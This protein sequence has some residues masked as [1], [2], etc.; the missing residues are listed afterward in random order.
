MKHIEE[1]EL[2]FRSGENGNFPGY[3]YP[4][5]F[6]PMKMTDAI[7]LAPIMRREGRTIGTYLGGYSVPNQWNIK[8]TQKWVSSC[9]LSSEFPSFHYLFLCG[10]NNVIGIGSIM[11]FGDDPRVC[12]FVISV[13]GKHQG[14]GWGRAIAKTLQGIAFDVWGF[15]KIYWLNDITNRRSTKL[16]QS[17]G[18]ALEESYSDNYRLGTSGTGLWFRWSMA[19]PSDMFPGVLQGAD[20]NY[21]MT[22]KSAEMLKAVIHAKDATGDKE[23]L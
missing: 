6:R 16:A 13:F 23:N 9:V 12:Q 18:F 1:V 21:W 4:A 8:D 2:K 19:R 5:E 7:L 14:K 20:M 11:K 15:E 17:L 22:P 10:P 3:D